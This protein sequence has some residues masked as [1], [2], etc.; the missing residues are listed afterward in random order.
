MIKVVRA[1]ETSVYYNE[2]TR[3]YI[4]ED[5]HLHTLRRENRNVPCLMVFCFKKHRPSLSRSLLTL[6][7]EKA[8]LSANGK[9]LPGMK[10]VA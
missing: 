8:F 3:R 4:L 10:G 6:S 5:S 2:T 1:S 9:R 7:R